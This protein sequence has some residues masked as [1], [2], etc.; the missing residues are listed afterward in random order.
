MAVEHRGVVLEQLDSAVERPACH[1]IEG[2]IGITIVDTFAAGLPSDDREDDHSETV[3]KASLELPIHD[4]H[5]SW[6]LAT[7]IY[8]V[9]CSRSAD[10]MVS[11]LAG[12]DEPTTRAG[13]AVLLGFGYVRFRSIS[14]GRR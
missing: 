1:H 14:G 5:G 3:D 10:A 12:V 9:H 13:H 2:N 7:K 4:G 6:T 11:R 8:G